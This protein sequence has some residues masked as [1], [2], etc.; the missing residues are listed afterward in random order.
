MKDVVVESPWGVDVICGTVYREAFSAAVA[1]E[2]DPAGAITRAFKDLEAEYEFVFFDCAG[3]LDTVATAS[4][5]GAD[6]GLGVVEAGNEDAI[7]KA[8]EIR[9]IG[10]AMGVPIG[11]I[12]TRW[13]SDRN[14]NL[15]EEGRL[16]DEGIFLLG[17]IHQE[18]RFRN[19]SEIGPL[20]LKYPDSRAGLNLFRLAQTVRDF[21]VMNGSAQ[22]ISATENKTS[23][24][25]V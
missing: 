1:A 17:R 4:L 25:E 9:D 15:R 22:A 14:V 12:E 20:G 16:L 23:K 21:G 6:Y 19:W 7:E 24:V 10:N 11:V 5:R 13:R 3:G 18:D 8:L 2:G